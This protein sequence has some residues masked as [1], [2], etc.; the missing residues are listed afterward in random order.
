MNFYLRFFIL[1]RLSSGGFS[2][3]DLPLK[4]FADYRVTGSNSDA[5]FVNFYQSLSPISDLIMFPAGQVEGKVEIRF[6]CE[7][8]YRARSAYVLIFIV[9]SLRP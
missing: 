7:D 6:Y 3:E 5:D 2:D 9:V 1:F 4:F 8:L